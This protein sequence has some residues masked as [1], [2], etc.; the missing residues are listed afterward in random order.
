MKIYKYYLA[1][2]FYTVIFLSVLT[3][4]TAFSQEGRVIKVGVG[5]GGS[6]WT[7][8]RRIA[9]SLPMETRDYNKTW[10]ESYIEIN[11]KNVHI[12]KVDFVYP[13]TIILW[14]QLKGLF[15]I[16]GK[17]IGTRQDM[18]IAIKKARKSKSMATRNKKR[19]RIVHKKIKKETIPLSR[20]A[21]EVTPHSNLAEKP[22]RTLSTPDQVAKK[23]RD[24]Q[25]EEMLN[26]LAIEAIPTKPSVGDKTKEKEVVLQSPREK[27]RNRTLSTP[28]QVTK[29]PKE[30]KVEETPNDLAV[31]A[32]TI[33]PSIGN[34]A[35]RAEEV[36]IDDTK[37]GNG[38]KFYKHFVSQWVRDKNNSSTIS[39]I[40]KASI[41]D[42][43]HVFITV[44]GTI[45]YKTFI[46]PETHI[47]EALAKEGARATKTYVKNREQGL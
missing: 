31:A 43:V 47:I 34:K 22:V 30:P 23:P 9:K 46:E 1:Y 6:V 28:G 27:K 35:K 44:D 8:T 32:I 40:E 16:E 11:G 12:S 2:I 5:K 20:K 36:V 41:L 26:D 13:E 18:M 38:K 7:A 15:E 42:G 25:V 17:K 37:T 3:P 39:I 14:T 4:N 24:P 29:K 33:K 10:N 45:I 21:K 19:N